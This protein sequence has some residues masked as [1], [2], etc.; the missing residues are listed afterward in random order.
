MLSREKVLNV[1]KSLKNWKHFFATC[2]G[3][4]A[5]DEAVDPLN[6]LFFRCESLLAPHLSAQ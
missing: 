3:S 6:T 5:P 2:E 4:L 1:L